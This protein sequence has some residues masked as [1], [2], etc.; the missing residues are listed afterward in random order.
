MSFVYYPYTAYQVENSV[1]VH[2]GETIT[3]ANESQIYASATAFVSPSLLNNLFT[4]VASSNEVTDVSF[5]EHGYSAMRADLISALATSGVLDTFRAAYQSRIGPVALVKTIGLTHAKLADMVAGVLRDS[6]LEAD[7]ARKSI[8]HQYRRAAWMPDTNGM[9]RS[10][11]SEGI[12]QNGDSMGF[13]LKVTIPP[14]T[15][16]S[17]PSHTFTDFVVTPVSVAIPQDYEVR[18]KL[19]LQMSYSGAPPVPP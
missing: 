15:I 6:T 11:A 2:A 3:Y 12:F 14:I 8:F 18:V 16:V 13:V 7:A 4:Y 17:T 1:G 9:Q 10:F 19:L 5:S